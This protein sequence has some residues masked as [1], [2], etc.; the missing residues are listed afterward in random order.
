MSLQHGFKKNKRGDPIF[1][2][3]DILPTIFTASPIRFQSTDFSQLANG[4]VIIEVYVSDSPRASNTWEANLVWR[5]MTD[6]TDIGDDYQ[7]S[8]RV[9]DS[10]NVIYGQQDVL[11][12]SPH[13]WCLDDTVCN[14]LKLR[15]SENLS[16]NIDLKL[17]VIMYH[18][19]SLQHVDVLDDAGN[20]IAPWLFLE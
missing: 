12:L 18:H 3:M 14:I 13:L 17:Q 2:R 20:I 11:T 9:V 19:T 1:K 10:D 16:E 7:V 8:V 4:V 6:P 5:I 15:I